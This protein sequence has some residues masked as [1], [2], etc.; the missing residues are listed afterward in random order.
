MGLKNHHLRPRFHL[1]ASQTDTRTDG[2]AKVVPDKDR[3][4]VD[5]ETQTDKAMMRRPTKA[6]E[7]K[8]LATKFEYFW[9]RRWSE[10]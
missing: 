4:L 6:D 10:P 7:N 8:K 3:S 5:T 2:R 1:R 9:L